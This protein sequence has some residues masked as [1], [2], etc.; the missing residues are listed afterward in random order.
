MPGKKRKFSSYTEQH[1]RVLAGRQLYEESSSNESEYLSSDEENIVEEQDISAI[2]SSGDADSSSELEFSYAD[3][4][5]QQPNHNINENRSTQNMEA[6]IID[7]ANA[8]GDFESNDEPESDLMCENDDSGDE[9]EDLLY[10]SDMEDADTSDPFNQKLRTFCLKHL[11]D[12]GM[13]E[14]L[15]LLDESGKFPD[16]PSSVDELLDAPEAHMP[17]PVKITNGEYMHLGIRPN[18]KLINISEVPNPLSVTISWDGVRIFKASRMQMWPIVMSVDDTN[19]VFLIGIFLGNKKPKSNMEYFYCL[20]RELEQISQNNDIVSVGVHGIQ[21]KLDVTKYLAD[22][23]ARLWAIGKHTTKKRFHVDGLTKLV[24][25]FL[26]TNGHNGYFSC[27][28][29]KQRG[30]RSMNRTSFELKSDEL[31]THEEAK[32][33]SDT[34]HYINE[35]PFTNCPFVKD[36]VY[37]FPTDLMHALDSGSTGKTLR[38]LI[39]TR[40]INVTSANLLIDAM[41]PYIPSDFPRKM[42]RLDDFEHYK[43]IE[44][45]YFGA[46]CGPVI[47]KQCCNNETY[48]HFLDYFVAYRIMMGKNGK[49]DKEMLKLAETLIQRF[50]EEFA[51]LYGEQHVSWNIHALLHV[52]KLVSIYGPIDKITCYKFEN[53]YMMMR[54]W[55]R[56]PSDIFQ[57]IFSRWKQTRGIAKAKSDTNKFGTF[58]YNHNRKD[59]CAML[60][61][62]TVVTITMQKITL[63]GIHLKGKRFLTYESLF[64][65]PINSTVLNIY[66]VSSLSETEEIV[67]LKDV[68][69]KMVLIPYNDKFVAMPVMHYQ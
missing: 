66:Q 68:E 60:K 46:Y 5:D 45:R 39:E 22:T 15:K 32:E 34:N 33:R 40:K 16:L 67:H 6:S 47:M 25:F 58:N 7:N 38:L 53:Y 52:P 37:S 10:F 56:K 54:R 30:F 3:Q 14:M 4:F 13:K 35:S 31:R 69:L 29:C 50:V 55:I 21:T 57:Q 12:T 24:L 28:Y 11:N 49:V 8:Q 36:L 17:T 27:N 20:N 26:G 41:T 43:A 18:L 2:Q 23:P 61:N 62:G 1:Q 63:N 19:I 48:K 59:S 64:E 42:R 44:L 65:A 51:R 9:Q